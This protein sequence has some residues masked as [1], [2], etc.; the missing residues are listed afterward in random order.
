MAPMQRELARP[1]S[2]GRT[3]LSIGVGFRIIRYLVEVGGFRSLKEIAAS[4]GMPPGKAHLYLASFVKEGLAAQDPVSGHYGLGPFATRIGLAAIRE[5][6]VI[7]LCRQPIDELCAATGC[8]AYVSIWG[9]L[10]PVIA[11]RKDGNRQGSMTIRIGYVMPLLFSATGHVFL[12]YLGEEVTDPIIRTQTRDPM[13]LVPPLDQAATRKRAK[14]IVAE[15]RARGY[16]VSEGDTNAGFFAAAA[17]IFD[18][19]GVIVA[20]LAAL[21]A[22]GTLPEAERPGI[23]L[24]V[25]DRA[26]AVSARL[27]YQ[28]ATTPR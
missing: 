23:R 13:R 12:S 1:R 26:D 2:S 3:I 24:M 5:N 28:P 25:K 6:E 18:H 14:G 21:G 19:A 17:P 16:A 15:V 7:A 10:G 8:A 11:Y 4:T 22:A 20:A 9:D 27:G